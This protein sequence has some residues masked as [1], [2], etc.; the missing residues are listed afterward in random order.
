MRIIVDVN[1]SPH[2]T[3]RLRDAG[4]QADHWSELGPGDALDID[5]MAFAQASHCIILTSDLDF[6]I[7]LAFSGAA[8]PSIVQLRAK[9]VSPKLIGDRV[10]EELL[11]LADYLEHGAVVTI[12]LT[13]TRITLLPFPREYR[14]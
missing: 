6:G 3:P 11:N 12:D 1:L 9:S 4:F 2:W 14:G 8:K 5:I 13:K 10:I 7:H